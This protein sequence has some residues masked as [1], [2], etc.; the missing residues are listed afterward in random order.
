[1]PPQD[2]DDDFPE[3]ME[4]EVEFPDDDGHQHNK[5]HDG[6]NY[7]PTEYPVKGENEIEVPDHILAEVREGTQAKE[8]VL[9]NTLL[10]SASLLF[11]HHDASNFV[12]AALRDGLDMEIEL[13]EAIPDAL[14]PISRLNI[15]TSI[16][17]Q[18]SLPEKMKNTLLMRLSIK[19][20]DEVILA[21]NRKRIPDAIA[22]MTKHYAATVTKSGVDPDMEHM[23]QNTVGVRASRK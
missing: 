17:N 11:A 1:M 3:V 20:A 4:I 18:M 10:E 7:R 13:D 15:V 19:T 6:I 8:E 23:P 22:A 14:V 2:D 9:R 21:L 12:E 16:V 5:M